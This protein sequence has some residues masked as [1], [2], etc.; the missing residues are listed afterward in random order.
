MG[1]LS[2]FSFQNDFFRCLLFIFYKLAPITRRELVK[3]LCE[4][5]GGEYAVL[6]SKP[7]KWLC[8]LKN[9]NCDFSYR[10]LRRVIGAFS[11]KIIVEINNDFS[12][13]TLK[14]VPRGTI[15]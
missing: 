6:R 7:A 11:C 14:I 3:N 12:L 5:G 8:H 4:G 10:L 9:Q 13:K 2:T 1:T 15:S